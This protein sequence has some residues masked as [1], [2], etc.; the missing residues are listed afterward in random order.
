MLVRQCAA[1]NIDPLTVK[2]SWAGA[3]GY[4]QFMPASL[5][6]AEDGDGDRKIDLYTFDDSIA[7]IARYLVEFGFAR[8]REKAVWG[9]NHEAAYVSGVLAFADALTARIKP[10]AG[11]P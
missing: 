9:Y 2:G 7:S 1:R 3:L 10:D 11:S 6:W 8:D 5:R 4:P